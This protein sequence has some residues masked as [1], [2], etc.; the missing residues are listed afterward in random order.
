VKEKDFPA[1]E[2]R[3]AASGTSRLSSIKT[4]VV[5][6]LLFSLIATVLLSIWIIIPNVKKNITSTTQSYMLDL[7]ASYGKV[8]DQNTNISIMYLHADRLETLLDN[9]GLQNVDSSYFY[10]L[11]PEGNILFHPDK[12]SIGQT[13][14]IPAVS[15][16]LEQVREGDFPEPDILSYD[17]KGQGI[18]A[19]YYIVNSGKAILFLTANENDVLKPVTDVSRLAFLYSSILALLLSISGYLLIAWMTRPIVTISEIIKKFANMDLTEDTR[20]EQICRRKDE[21]GAMGTALLSL[22]SAL[23]DVISDIKEQSALLYRTSESL[24]SSAAET[25]GTVQNV[26]RAVSEIAVG[27]ASQAEETQKASDDIL[28]IGNMVQNTS[29]EVSS[30]RS[31]AQSIRVSSDMADSTLHELHSVNQRAIDSINI[32]YK[33]THTTNES[34][35]KIREATSLISAIADET[36]LLSLNASIEAARAGEAGRGFAVVASQIQKL[37][38]QSNE[39]ASQIDSIIHDLLEDSQKAVETMES[40][41]EI[42][43]QQN[44]NVTQTGSAFT[45]VQGGI[46]SSAAN[47]DTIAN[48]TDQLNSA[49]VNI[50]DVVQNLTS[51]AEQ[52]AANTQETSAAVLEVANIMQEISRYASKLQEIASSLETNVDTFQL[53]Q[54]Q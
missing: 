13:A 27:A 30:L 34:A 6:V 53:D 2:K 42:M 43:M 51:I 41:R 48:R 18:Y 15:S 14:D 31:I 23:T 35:L 1:K 44:E 49:R 32:I 39:S 26:E 16:L 5:S 7:T 25:A 40:V 47:V 3:T 8:L 19:S 22:R 33:Q 4:R 9:V 29:S 54:S 28:I 52:N 24:N 12:N 36:S 10:V 46:A 45:Q 38:E 11:G 37:A 20:L 21:T 17:Y 50:V